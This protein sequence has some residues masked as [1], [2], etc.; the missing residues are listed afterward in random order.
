MKK[1]LKSAALGQAGINFIEKVISKMGYV[2]R[3]T[4][5]FDAG[6]DGQI[7]IRN[8]ESEDLTNCYVNVQSKAGNSYFKNENDK[9]FEFICEEKDI[10]Y[11]LNGNI[12]TILVVSKPFDELGY[13]VNVNEY[14]NKYPERKVTKKIAFDKETDLFDSSIAERLRNAAIPSDKGIYFP[15]NLIRETLYTNLIPIDSFPDSIYIA[16][17]EY[18]FNSEIWK[19]KDEKNLKFGG[20]WFLKNKM[21]YSFNN[22]R[23]HP[24]KEI[25]DSESAETINTA[26]WAESNN[27]DIQKDFVKLLK[28]TLADIL[29]KNYY[30]YNRDYNC[31]YFVPQKSIVSD[32][33][34]NENKT[35]IEANYQSFQNK[36]AV[37]L[38]K[39][40]QKKDIIYFY[41]HLAFECYFH[42]YG[43]KWYLRI[44]PTYI[45]TYDGFKKVS[46]RNHE[47]VTK[48]KRNEDNSNLVRYVRLFSQI[49][50]QSSQESFFSQNELLVFGKLIELPSERGFVDSEWIKAEEKSP[51][52]ETLTLFI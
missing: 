13:W 6:I 47:Y 41:R 16:P 15:P 38:F 17:T 14:F 9:K 2:W 34:T 29:F 44:S 20:S 49:L 4:S 18:R 45:F 7:E 26:E 48:L 25:C 19:V 37:T 23:H 51:D 39:K 33:A 11:W 35:T 8:P 1:L 3:P 12:A 24:F 40:F 52:S 42:N 32:M 31:Y 22:L 36:T 27:E 30:R 21:I 10:D 5:I 46:K 50:N 43:N 28:L